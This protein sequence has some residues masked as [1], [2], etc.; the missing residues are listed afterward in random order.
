[1]F[2]RIFEYFEH[3]MVKI[4]IEIMPYQTS[5]SVAGK[6]TQFPKLNQSLK[7]EIITQKKKK[8]VGT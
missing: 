1:M 4:G 7:V 5:R 3:L 6:R 8:N 2:V